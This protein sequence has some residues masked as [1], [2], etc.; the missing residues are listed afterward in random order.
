LANIEHNTIVDPELH[1]P[2][3]IAAASANQVYVADGAASGAFTQ[4]TPANSVMVHSASDLP[5]AVATVRTLAANTIYRV[6]GS[7]SIGGDTLVLGDNTTIRGD[8]QNVDKIVSTTSGTLLTATAASFR[9]YKIGFTCS[10]GTFMA[11]SGTSNSHSLREVSVTC[12]TGGT[13]TAN[14]LTDLWRSRIQC[15]TTGLT[16]SGACFRFI[17][18]NATIDVTTAAGIC[19][20]FGTATFDN[21]RVHNSSINNAASVTGLDIAPSGA[22]LNAGAKGFVINTDFLTAATATAGFVKGDAGWNMSGNVGLADNPAEAQGYI[23]DSALTTTFAGTGVGNEVIC[24]FGA[25]WL[26]SI[27]AKFTV[28]T[29]GVYTYTG[30]TPITVF[31]SSNI[32]ASIGGGASRTYNFYWRKNSTTDL[33]SVSQRSFDGTNPG[34]L[35]CS[36]IIDLVNGDTL[37][38]YVRAETATT[39]MTVDTVSTKIIQIAG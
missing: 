22:N 38:L 26:S 37:A 7:V 24:N 27:A 12:D 34:S 4:I 8:N 9:L 21:I 39:A 3:G 29:A 31:A 23:V 28:T 20:D 2:K 15:T 35:S 19:V 13:I 18:D 10:S 11:V 6:S 30:N 16:F 14:R 1:E 17:M 36:S 33:S 5:A 25:A 32:F